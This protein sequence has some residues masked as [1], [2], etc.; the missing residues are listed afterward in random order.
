MVWSLLAN[1]QLLYPME[2]LENQRLKN[3]LK[4]AKN[5]SQI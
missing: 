3:G 4:K 5:I 1:V 2:A